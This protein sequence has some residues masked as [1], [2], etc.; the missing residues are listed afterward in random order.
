[1]RRQSRD[2]A[3]DGRYLYVANHNPDGP[4]DVDYVASKIS[5]I[6]TQTKEVKDIKLVNGS[7]GVRGVKLSPD[8][9]YMYAT[10]FMA[11]FLVPTTQLERGWVS[12]DA[13]SV[14]RVSDMT[15]QYTVLLDDVDLGFSNPWAMEFSED[16]KTLIISSAAGRELSFIDLPAMTA[17]IEEANANKTGASH[18]DAHN[19]LSFLSGIRQRFNLNGDGPRSM[20]V[21][22]NTV[23]TANYYSDSI[24]TVD[25]SN[26]S[27]ITMK[28]VELNP[29]A[30]ITDERQGEIFFND[31]NLCF[32][33]WMSCTTCL[34]RRVLTH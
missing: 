19:D 24:D 25:F 11:R 17:K 3:K 22:G 5:V 28:T 8:G 16:A 15:L 7:E 12:T 34:P 21:K 2:I 23:F 33:K 29:D 27:G 18:L 31:S 13:L 1:M 30:V 9:K 32:Q 10:H 14:I 26:L 6:D 20:I 4:A